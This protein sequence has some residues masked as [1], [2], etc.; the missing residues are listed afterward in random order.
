MPRC[1]SAEG[2]AKSACPKACQRERQ[3]DQGYPSPCECCSQLYSAPRRRETKSPERLQNAVIIS[4]GPTRRPRIQSSMI[5]S[6]ASSSRSIMCNSSGARPSMYRSTKLPRSRSASLVP[7]CQARNRILR[8]STSSVST[9]F[10]LRSAFVGGG[11]S[12]VDSVIS[13]GWSIIPI[14]CVGSSNASCS[15]WPLPD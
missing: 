7:Q 4:V 5:G 12:F 11:S 14:N 9:S 15:I 13:A 3:S 2:T 1:R 8:R 10:E 6:S